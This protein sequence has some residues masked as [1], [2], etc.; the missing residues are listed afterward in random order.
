MNIQ[1]AEEKDVDFSREEFEKSLLDEMS[2]EKLQAEEELLKLK[3]LYQEKLEREVSYRNAKIKQYFIL[4]VA[5]SVLIV[6]MTVGYYVFVFQAKQQV[7]FKNSL[8]NE[9]LSQFSSIEVNAESS[10][11]EFA[12][13][14]NTL[15]FQLKSISDIVDSG[16][17]DKNTNAASVALSAKVAII[18]AKL[19][20]IQSSNVIEKVANIESSIKGDPIKMLSIPLLKNDLSNLKANY[21]RDLSRL[22]GEIDRTNSQLGFFATTTIS[23]LIAIF[24]ALIAPMLLD[25]FSRKR[26]TDT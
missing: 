10:L 1:K 9:V 22:R 3:R 7:E 5:I 14:S 11:Q 16:V 23:L 26:E 18:E 21:E 13:A 6:I 17:F 4:S 25:L 24:T 2:R 12:T 15:D 19:N 20:A 8:Q